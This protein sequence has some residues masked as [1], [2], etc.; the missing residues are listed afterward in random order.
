V[1][2]E[3]EEPVPTARFPDMPTIE[4]MLIGKPLQSILV[5]TVNSDGDVSHY[6]DGATT[7]EALGMLE[8][9]KQAVFLSDLGFEE[10]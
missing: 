10:E 9:L 5:L 4:S 2:V 8:M 7:M 3:E 1:A 6:V